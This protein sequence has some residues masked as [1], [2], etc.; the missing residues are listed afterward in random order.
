MRVHIRLPATFRLTNPAIL[1]TKDL[2][3]PFMR[4]AKLGYTEM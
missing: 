1:C 3:Q 2:G 4:P